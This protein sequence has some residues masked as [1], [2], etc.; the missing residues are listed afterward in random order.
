MSDLR[1][2]AAPIGSVGF[3]QIDESVHDSMALLGGAAAQEGGWDHA[4]GEAPAP[5]SGSESAAVALICNAHTLMPACPQ[6]RHEGGAA[7]RSS[8]ANPR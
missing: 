3:P 1:G 4:Q 7:S 2:R 8:A 5:R 6:R